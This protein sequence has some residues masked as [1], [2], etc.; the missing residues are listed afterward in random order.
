MGINNYANLL[1]QVSSGLWKTDTTNTPGYTNTFNGA[2]PPKLPFQVTLVSLVAEAGNNK[3][4]EGITANIGILV[5]FNYQLWLVTRQIDP[6]SIQFGILT[7]LWPLGHHICSRLLLLSL[8]PI[9]HLQPALGGLV[10]IRLPVLLQLGKESSE[11]SD[12]GR[13]ALLSRMV[14]RF[15]P[16]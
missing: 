6:S 3:S 2:K 5:W 16:S 12:G 1:R 13:P 4:F 9:A 11:A 10:G 14:R 8:F 15:Y 7:L